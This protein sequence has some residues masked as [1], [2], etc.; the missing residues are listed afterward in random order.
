M[1]GKELRSIL[2]K[3]L[4]AE[5]GVRGLARSSGLSASHVSRI[6]NG[7][8]A[9]SDKTLRRLGIECIRTAHYRLGVRHG[10]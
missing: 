7:L 10:S 8:C 6:K 9:P 1:S 2:S 4:R 5:G 3:R